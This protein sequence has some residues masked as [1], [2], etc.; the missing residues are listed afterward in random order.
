MAHSV[1]ILAILCVIITTYLS[2]P[3]P[4]PKNKTISARLRNRIHNQ[5]ALTQCW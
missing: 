2:P 1:L 4:R 5:R 3:L